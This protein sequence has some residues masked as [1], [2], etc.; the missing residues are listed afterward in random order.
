MLGIHD[1]VDRRFTM[2]TTPLAGDGA[3]LCPTGIRCSDADRERTGER[4]RTAAG[5]GR[6]SM[7]ELD[8]RLGAAYGATYQHELA[9]LTTDLPRAAPASTGWWAVL[10]LL[11]SQLATE[12]AILV[13]RTRAPARRRLM[14]IGAVVVLLALI[15]GVVGAA[16]HGFGAGGHGFGPGG[17]GFG[18]DRF[19]PDGTFGH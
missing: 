14:L 7:T 17:R 15:A 2:T 19:G 8:E 9:A 18:G 3:E 16:V 10:A 4:L 12:F 6:L 1:D 11:R 13:G 5:E